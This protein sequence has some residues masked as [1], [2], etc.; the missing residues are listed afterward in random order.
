[1]TTPFQI[2]GPS[3]S[4]AQIVGQP[5]A[6]AVQVQGAPVGSGGGGSATEVFNQ[7]TPA[8][9]WIISHSFGRLPDVSI[10]IGGVEVFSDVQVT[11]TTAT[12]SFPSPQSGIAVLQ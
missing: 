4:T 6:T 12:I 3:V 7:S 1:M 5:Y 11:N 2:I 8:S 10:F 9:T